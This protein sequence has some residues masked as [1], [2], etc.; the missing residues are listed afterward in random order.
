MSQA[1]Q[2][3]KAYRWRF[4]SWG[5]APLVVLLVAVSNVYGEPVPRQTAVISDDL[6]RESLRVAIRHSVSYLE[7][8]PPDRVVGEE[9]RR[10]TAREILD[11]LLAFEKLLDRWDCRECWT[12]EFN[13][14]FE[15]IPSASDAASL[16]VLFTGYYQPVI[17][18]SLMPTAEYR[19]PLYG[20]PA[21][22]ITAEQV[23]LTPAATTEKVVGRLE[24]EN[25]VPYYSRREIDDFGSLR[26]RGYEIAWL[27]DPIDLFFLHIQGSGI[28]RLPDGRRIGVGYAA[29]NGR[30]Y[31]SIGRLLIDDGKIS[32]EEMSMQRLR[33][34]LREHPEELSEILAYNESYIFFRFVEG[35]LGSLEVPVTAGRSIATDLRLFP[36]GALAFI[37]TQEPVIDGAGRLAGW[38]PFSRIVLNQDSGGAIRGFQRV[39]LFFG[40]GHGTAAAAG[41]MNSTGKLFFLVLKNT[42]AAK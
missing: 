16:E 28:L 12:K 19:Y 30:A 10:F 18:G 29:Q 40:T 14:R 35:P 32:Q 31:R 27:K 39:D 37:E 33:G 3:F 11:T 38:T 5:C 26:G 1:G 2:R 24:G 42:P 41:Y 6:D 13:E 7:K 23:I 36:K 34:Y 4:K 17:D 21:D 20:K 22:M 8:L 15:L 25:F 9:P